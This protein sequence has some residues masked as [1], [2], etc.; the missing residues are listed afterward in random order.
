VASY[1]IE[2]KRS[3]AKELAELPKQDCISQATC[4]SCSQMM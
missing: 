1:S 4:D 3:A 2:T